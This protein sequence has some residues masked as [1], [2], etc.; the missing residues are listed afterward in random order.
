VTTQIDICNMALSRLGTQSTITSLTDGS[1]E[2]NAC[3]TFYTVTLNAVLANPQSEAYP[4]YSWQWARRIAALTTASSTNPR[5][6][7]ECALPADCVDVCELVDNSIPQARWKPQRRFF[8]GNIPFEEGLGTAGTTNLIPVIWTDLATPSLVLISNALPLANWPPA[9]LEAF[10]YHLAHRIAIPLTG[11]GELA[12]QMASAASMMTANAIQADQ[13]VELQSLDY[14]PDDIKARGPFGGFDMFGLDRERWAAVQQTT[15][16][17]AAGFE[18]LT[19]ASPEA[20]PSYLSAAD[21]LTQPAAT[22]LP[23]GSN[24]ASDDYQYIPA[25][26][27]DGRIGVLAIGDSPAGWRRPYHK[28][29]DLG[30][31][32]GDGETEE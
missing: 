19:V 8:E 16:T 21:G 9:F 10:T 13:R 7:Y 6:T 29:I 20:T 30:A 12:A 24:F 25:D 31:T 2:A 5:W 15:T 1:T 23:A 22:G 3:N 28:T 32:P 4:N 27:P 17:Y 11:S 18:A 14:V 26:T